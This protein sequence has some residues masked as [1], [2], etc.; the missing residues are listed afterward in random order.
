MWQKLK[1]WRGVKGW[2]CQRFHFLPHCTPWQQSCKCAFPFCFAR[3]GCAFLLDLEIRVIGRAVFLH[4]PLYSVYQT[5]TA[6]YCSWLP[7]PKK[8]QECTTLVVSASC[9]TTSSQHLCG[10]FHIR[11]QRLERKKVNNFKHDRYW[12]D[13]TVGAK[14]N[15]TRIPVTVL[16]DVNEK[17]DKNSGDF[18]ANTPAE[19]LTWWLRW[20]TWL[21]WSS[22]Y[23]NLSILESIPVYSLFMNFIYIWTQ[24]GHSRCAQCKFPLIY[25]LIST[26]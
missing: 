3:L 23:F 20:L 19:W 8:T 22:V 26:V 11:L 1:E 17:S 15:P 4:W 2:K 14:K 7:R 5:H 13:F 16:F 9:G 6:T 10:K 12:F 24:H 25:C 18:G 21:H